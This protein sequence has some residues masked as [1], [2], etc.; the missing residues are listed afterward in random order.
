M[1]NPKLSNESLSM[2]VESLCNVL[3][4]DFGE[5]VSIHADDSVT[6]PEEPV[7]MRTVSG[8]T[9]QFLEVNGVC[10]SRIQVRYFLL[11]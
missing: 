5:A 7:S 6:M 1:L 3:A 9:A 8:P 2:I 4:S 10:E 11:M